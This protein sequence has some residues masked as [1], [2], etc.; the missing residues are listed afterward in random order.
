MTPN[1]CFDAFLSFNSVDGQKVRDIAV[2]LEAKGLK[3]YLEE[4]EIRP[5]QDFQPRLAEALEQSKACVVFL[6]PNGLGPWQKQE[7]QVAIDTKARDETFCVIPVLLPG[8]ERRAGATWRTWNSSSTRRGSSSSGRSMTRSRST[9]SSGASRETGHDRERPEIQRRL[10]LSRAGSVHGEGRGVLF[11]PREPHGLA[12]QRPSSR[13]LRRGG[14]AVSRGAR[15]IRERQVVGRAGGD[16]PEPEGRSDRGERNLASGRSPA[17]RRSPRQPRGRS[18]LT[19]PRPRRDPGRSIDPEARRRPQ[20]QSVRARPL[21]ARRCT[22][23]P[24]TSACS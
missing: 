18:R 11:R 5:G 13:G 1:K 16:D 22:T 6:G 20:G 9:A 12:G 4:W 3:P 2:R 15:T 24:S 8:T 14:R 23:T 21:R 7:I 19:V 17:G 10:P